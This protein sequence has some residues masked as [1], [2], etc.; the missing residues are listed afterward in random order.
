M[1]ELEIKQEEPN[2]QSK[3]I[4]YP[5]NPIK[6]FKEFKNLRKEQIIK[7]SICAVIIILF[8]VFNNVKVIDDPIPSNHCY[9]DV[10]L[11]WLRPLN[12][13]FRGSTVFRSFMSIL[14]SLL[15]DI[16]FLITYF[17]W[18]IYSV[19][20]RYSVTTMLFYGPRGLVQEIIRLTTP[21][22]L[23]FPYPGFP[24]IVV[25]YIQGSD[26]FWSGHCG[27][28]IIGMM[29]FIWM[30]RY[31]LAGFC[32]FVSFVEIVLMT[33]SREHYTIDIIVGL[34]FSHYITIHSRTLFKFIYDHIS[35]LDKLKQQNREE[36]KRI[37]FN[38]DI[39]D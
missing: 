33:M 34:V 29:E 30:K 24:S 1:E 28:P 21:D 27:F 36:L 22:R 35:F 19:D 2:N 37:N 26:F 8:G 16:V 9:Y 18:A 23:Y 17:G 39:G 38:F 10:V 25:G 11:E 6:V 31:Y 5:S 7:V 15:I 20:W 32:G 14:G 4:L 12:D 13:Y 3:K